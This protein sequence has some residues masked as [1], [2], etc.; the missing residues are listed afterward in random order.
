VLYIE[1][2]LGLKRHEQKALATPRLFALPEPEKKLRAL[3][4]TAN[5][6]AREA[7]LRIDQNMAVPPASLVAKSFCANDELGQALHAGIENLNIWRHS[8]GDPVG[9]AQVCV[10]ARRA[11]ERVLAIL[12]PVT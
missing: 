7:G 3:I 8:N 4:A 9:H 1:A 11:G 10:E 6:H 5:P 12:Q 2:G